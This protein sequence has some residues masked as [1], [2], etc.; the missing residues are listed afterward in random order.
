[1]VVR[2]LLIKRGEVQKIL[3]CCKIF[4]IHVGKGLSPGRKVP[5]TKHNIH[6]KDLAEIDHGGLGIV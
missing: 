5:C 1:M 2:D 6:K 4:L 3:K